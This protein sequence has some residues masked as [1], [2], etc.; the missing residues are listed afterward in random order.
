MSRFLTKALAAATFLLV[1]ASFGAPPVIWN[2]ANARFINSGTIQ[3]PGLTPAGVCTVDGTGLFSTTTI[4]GIL[5]SQAG[6]AGEYL[7]TNGT[8]A[9]WAP[10]P[11]APTGTPNSFAG[12]N[13]LGNIDD[14]PTWLQNVYG[15]ADETIVHTPTDPGVTTA[16]VY[17]QE[18][19]Q[20]TPT[21]N[22]TN[23]FLYGH[24][25]TMQLLGSNDFNGVTL[26]ETL[27][28]QQ[29]ASD[30]L[31]EL[32][33]FFPRVAMGVGGGTNSSSTIRV[34]KPE[35]RLSGNHTTGDVRAVSSAVNMD[36][37]TTATTA[38][39]YYGSTYVGGTTTDALGIN[40]EVQVD[41]ISTNTTGMRSLVQINGTDTTTTGINNNI[42][43]VGTTTNV[44]GIDMPINNALG[45]VANITA[46]NSNVNN[47][48][49]SGNYVGLSL[50]KTGNTGGSSSAISINSQD[51]IT[52]S[53]TGFGYNRNGATTGNVQVMNGFLNSSSPVASSLWFGEFGSDAAITGN[54]QGIRMNQT[55]TVAGSF[56]GYGIY[57]NDNI[58]SGTGESVQLFDANTSIGTVNGN[59]TGVNIANSMAVTGTNNTNGFVFNNQGTGYR[60]TGIN[61]S[62]NQAMTE[63]IRGLQYNTTGNARTSTGIDVQM[64]GNATDDAQ[65]I[66]VNVSSQTSSSTTAHVES[67]ELQG[68]VVSIQSA[69]T[70]F[71]SF[72]VDIGN[73][74]TATSTIQSGSPLTG[75]DQIITLIQSNLLMNDN[76][77]TGP[78]GL[79]TVMLGGVSQ[80][81]ISGAFT[82]PVLRSMLLGTT[83]P[84]GSGGT[85]TEHVTLELLGLPSFGGSVTAPTKIAIQDSQL[86]GQDY[87]Q[88]TTANQCWGIRIRDEDSENF[89]RRLAINTAGFINA[90]NVR[91]EVL[92]GHWRS[93][94][95][96]A[97]TT[98][99]NA[100]AGTG[101]TCTVA[102][103]TDTAGTIELVTGSGAWAAGVQCDMNFNLTYNTAPKCVI[104][105]VN[106]N[107]A[108]ASLNTFLTK[109]TTA[110]SL[111]FVNADV[112]ATTYQWDYH[113]VETN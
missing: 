61:L 7:T 113:C 32:V 2:G 63:E 18:G 69:F 54:F 47:A 6:N 97:P 22:Q 80:I 112:A 90:A 88:G 49:I 42:N 67:V 93:N 62:N 12:Y 15:G 102:Q 83:V 33:S 13:S 10:V 71:P 3:V 87:C 16:F 73:N 100:N 85:V 79:D 24:L 57:S 46:I 110:M 38:T 106:N 31:S 99:P 19:Y 96:T 39:T 48:P 94:Q 60:Y 92:D 109:S 14:I 64:S 81:G 72:G 51:T 5:P 20:I 28:S 11:S 52:G 105:P 55:G 103:A 1:S 77:S 25:D 56:T 43:I 111:N 98:T 89:F 66:R 86:V 108:L 41:G 45:T 70:P 36:G 59:Y 27:I 9:S 21:N 74:F 68:G 58:G 84:S 104:T 53:E 65:G 44:F 101:A 8:N 107:A 35:V 29:G 91:L 23:T 4:D 17:N 76:I 40:Q 95:T 50:G 82:V 75:T 34:V 37:G 26:Q 30:I 78:F